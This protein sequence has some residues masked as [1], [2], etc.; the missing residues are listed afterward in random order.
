MLQYH[1]H[2]KQRQSRRARIAK[3]LQ[4]HLHDKQLKH[5]KYNLL[6]IKNII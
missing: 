1:L 3:I 2:D 6:K 4:Y 5:N